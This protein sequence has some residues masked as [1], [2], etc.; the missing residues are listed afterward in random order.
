MTNKFTLLILFFLFFSAISFAQ[1]G[2]LT[3]KITDESNSQ[4]LA[5][6]TISLIELKKTATSEADGS[7]RFSNLVPG[8]YTLQISFVGFNTK[9]I[10]EIEIVR[11]DVT[12]F[13]VTL[14]PMKGSLDAVVVTTT[15]AKKESLNTLL[16][17]RRNA[18]VVSDGI[19][20][21]LI[22]KSPD[23]NT[24]D[25]LKRISGTSVQENK[26]VVVRGMNDR[27]NEAMLNGFILPSSE[28]DRKTFAFDIFPS[29]VVDNIT[30]YKSASP[31]LPG[32][33]AGGLVQ[34]TTKD[35]PDK[36]FFSI[37]TTS[38]LNTQA[39]SNDFYTYPG[40]KT[41]WLGFDNKVRVLPEA[42]ANTKTHDFNALTYD[43]PAKKS[44]LDRSF[45]NTWGIEK[46]AGSLLNAGLQMSGGFN[47]KLSKTSSYPRLGG[48]FGVTYNSSFNYTQQDR[49]YYQDPTKANPDNVDFQFK[50]S[51][52]VQNILTSAL[53]NISFK[54]NRNNKIFFN[55]IIS[56]NSFD[57]MVIRGGSYNAL[58]R[59][60]IE[61]YSY[62]F[63]SNR[64]INTQIGGE[65]Y[66]PGS[67]IK[68]NWTGYYTDLKRNE[69]DYRYV[70]YQRGS[71]YDPYAAVLAYGGQLSTTESGLR[72]FGG[73]RDYSKGANADV[74]IPFKLFKNN[75]SFKF[76]GGYYYDQRKRNIRFFNTNSPNNPTEQSGQY[77]FQQPGSIFATSHFDVNE[78][79]YLNEPELPENS[80]QGFVRNATGFLMFDN[81]FTSK[82][83]LVWGLR[84]EDYRNQ[85]TGLNASFE[86]TTFADIKKAD[87]LPSG[88]L[89]YSIL[90]KANLRAS[91]GRTVTRPLFR[92]LSPQVFYDFFL[93]IT[94][95]GNASLVPTYINNYEVRWE[96]F[97]KNSQYYSVS[98]FFKQLKDPIEPRVFNPSAES[99]SQIYANVDE[100]KNKGIE[101]E[102]RKD[103]GFFGKYFENLVLYTNLSLI[104]SDVS[105]ADLVNTKNTSRPL[106][107]QSPYLLNASLQYTEPKSN[108]AISFLY[109]QAGTRIWLLDAIYPNIVWEKP[110]PI[111]DFKI[112]KTVFKKGLVEFS[113][114]DV[115]H[116]DAIF[117]NDINDNQK[118]DKGTDITTIRRTFGSTV[119]LAI[120]YKF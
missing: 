59:P 67:K 91:Y 108:I 110:R 1:N 111:F 19:S 10:S 104:K 79:L 40:S 23:K 47:A 82:L 103:F 101:L 53:G 55:N 28:P 102:V 62:Y 49:T 9:K 78:G 60:M 50:D 89:V 16:V 45:Q 51:Q 52:Y 68:I 117:F 63:V 22:K 66:L 100:A 13:N 14:V 54:I 24:S 57:Q 115:L 26:Y 29:E 38:G 112:S 43:D 95:F 17:T 107:G 5:G 113:W 36:A 12:T 70:T 106:F 42:I 99:L 6:A 96:H 34:I 120:G 61:A 7:Y 88:N 118:Y 85:L 15:S 11:G 33:F 105:S 75:Q 93:N 2:N 119:S 27:Y 64:L 44:A 87:W 98:V 18:P 74:S 116:K 21:D 39:V 65:H 8:K 58:S 90:P 94:Y 72:F 114:A 25:V 35:V 32:S 97:F 37:K 84:L 3:G 92:E 31:D 73:V 77:I 46:K 109:N 83:R 41:D 81:R 69:P 76:G 30:I 71:E 56:L 80:Y 48:I 20:A 4:T 86:P